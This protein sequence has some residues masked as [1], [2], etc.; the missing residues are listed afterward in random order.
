MFAILKCSYTDSRCTQ[1]K[2]IMAKYRTELPQ[3][4]A[5]DLLK[6]DEGGRERVSGKTL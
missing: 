6:N 4:A 3:F 2:H 1:L 5:F